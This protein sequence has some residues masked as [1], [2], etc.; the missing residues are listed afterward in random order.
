MAL[1]AKYET[2]TSFD[3]L[4]INPNERSPDFSMGMNRMELIRLKHH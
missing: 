2:D 3:Y 1:Y 4:N